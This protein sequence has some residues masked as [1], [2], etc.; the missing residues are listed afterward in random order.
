MPLLRNRAYYHQFRAFE[1]G[2]IIDRRCNGAVRNTKTVKNALRDRLSISRSVAQEWQA[3]TGQR[4][5]L[6]L[7]YR[8]IRYFGLRWHRGWDCSSVKNVPSGSG[9]LFVPNTLE[10]GSFLNF[11]PAQLGLYWTCMGH[12]ISRRLGHLPG[13][14]MHLHRLRHYVQVV[15]SRRQWSPYSESWGM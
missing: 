9:I 4:P 2:R 12:M 14:S 8:R 11:F 7:V 6:R 3:T 10:L 1:R 5:S 13:L 15:S